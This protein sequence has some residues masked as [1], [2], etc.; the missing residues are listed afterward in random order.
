M[1]GSRGAFCGGDNKHTY[2]YR[3]IDPSASLKMTTGEGYSGTSTMSA[4][5][6]MRPNYK[7]Q[8]I[9]RPSGTF[10]KEEGLVQGIIR[11]SG[12]N[13]REEGLTQLTEQSNARGLPTT[14][15]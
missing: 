1:A 5:C 11:P 2:H 7:S 14:D 10:F 6:Q 15:Y 4:Q 3:Q 12:T 8:S 9:I 13:F